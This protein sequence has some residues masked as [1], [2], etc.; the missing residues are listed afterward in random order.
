V[1]QSLGG[2]NVSYITVFYSVRSDAYSLELRDTLIYQKG[3]PCS[4]CPPGFPNC[5]DGLCC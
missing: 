2:P 4:K 1:S 5:K 3:E